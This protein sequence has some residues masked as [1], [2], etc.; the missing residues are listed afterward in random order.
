LRIRGLDY[1]N[2]LTRGLLHF[3]LLPRI[4]AQRAGAIGLSPQAL[5]RGG[6]RS[7][8]GSERVTD[9]GVVVDVLRHHLEDLW[10]I[11]ERDECGIESL[12]LGCIGEGCTGQACVFHQPVINVQNFLG[13]RRGGGDLREQRIGIKGDW[14]EQLVE[15]FGRRNVRLRRDEKSEVLQKK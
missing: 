8:I 11:Y 10:K 4:A 3:H 13:I 6:D 7:L 9:N 5:D 1:I 12:L 14:R 15:F 2:R